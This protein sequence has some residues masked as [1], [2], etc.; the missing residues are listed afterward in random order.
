MTGVQTCALP[1]FL[2]YYTDQSF[3]ESVLANA[4]ENANIL[5]LAQLFG[6]R[7]KL[8]TPATVVLDVYQL[9]PA[10]GIGNSAEPDYDY[11]LSI[12]ENVQVQTIEGI[13]F[14]TTQPVDFAVNTAADPRE[15]SVYSTDAIG[16][17][18]FFLL[19]KQVPGKSGE[20]KTRTYT[21]Q[22]PKAYDKITLPETNVID[23]IDVIS[24]SGDEW[25]EVDHMIKN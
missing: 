15:A 16:N 3:R 1:I 25:L 22:A 10:K 11:A 21:F 23:V 7:T 9:V 14:V 8:N 4:Q 18:E 19:R 13:N 20:I 12:K 17:I 24:S 5:Q 6:Y 2:S